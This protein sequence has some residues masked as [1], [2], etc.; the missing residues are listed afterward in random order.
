MDRINFIENHQ[1]KSFSHLSPFFQ[2]N[3]IRRNKHPV[4]TTPKT[5]SLDDETMVEVD[6][7][8]ETKKKKHNA[9]LGRNFFIRSPNT[10]T[11]TNSTNRIIGGKT[12]VRRRITPLFSG[13]LPEEADVVD[14]NQVHKPNDVVENE[15]ENI[16]LL[17]RILETEHKPIPIGFK[18]STY[19]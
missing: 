14:W 13:P 7:E 19:S 2:S 15:N 12:P 8:H 9:V 1:E 10:N 11:N 6:K 4:A 17:S 18:T 3:R 16:I 5:V